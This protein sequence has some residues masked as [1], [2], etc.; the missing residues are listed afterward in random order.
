MDIKIL[1]A[2]DDD[3]LRS[4]LCDIIK[5]QGYTPIP[6]TDGKEAI[7]LYFSTL[8]ISLCILDVMMPEYDGWQVLEEIRTVDETPILM[9]TALE[10]EQY[11][12]KGLTHGA[13]DYIAKPFSYP[14][15]I[16]RIERLLRKVKKERTSV[17]TYGALTIDQR[18]R[19]VF[20]SQVEI[21]L[22]NKEYRLL[23]YLSTNQN[24]VLQRE[25][26]LDQLWGMD[27]DGDIRVVDT[28]IKMLRHKLG[29]CACYILTIRG[30]GYQFEVKK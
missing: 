27:F 10:E 25:Q 13:D 3:L 5:K 30:V 22:N 6:A 23:C 26:I 20:V 19:K 7:D 24:R 21:A 11:E 9:L 2:D 29:V 28:H 17:Q 12:I 4:L 16:A 14:V 15:L 8:D 1:V 18:L